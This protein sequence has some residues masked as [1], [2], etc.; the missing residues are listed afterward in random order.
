MVY[1]ICHE[2]KKKKEKTNKQITT[3]DN[4]TTIRCHAPLCVKDDIVMHPERRWKVKFG[5]REAFHT[6][7]E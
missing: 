1:F 4:P 3:D 6:L 7:H 5:R 2:R